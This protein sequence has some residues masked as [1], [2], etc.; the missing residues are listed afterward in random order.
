LQR[1]LQPGEIEALDRTRL[2]RMRMPQPDSLF[3]DRAARLRQLADGNPIADY[4]RFVARLVDAQRAL[5]RQFAADT[6]H[7]AETLDAQ[8]IAQAQRHAMPL[9]PAADH[10]PAAW[11]QALSGILAAVDAAAETPA[12]L[13]DAVARL[14]ALPALDQEDL[15]QQ[16]LSGTLDPGD[17]ALAPLLMA[18]LQVIYTLRASRIPA[19]EVPYT[20]P[21]TVCPVCASAP[22]AS[23]QRLGVEPS[24]LR[25]A[26]CG[27]CATEWH[28]VRVK[29]T[30]CESTEGVR[31]QGVDGA[32][33]PSGAVLA[34]TCDACGNYRKLA[35]QEKDPLAEP[36]ADD[37]ASIVLD[38]LMGETGFARASANP[39]LAL[40]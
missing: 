39:L 9:L 24:G 7:A 33:G 1:I 36:L 28:M 19:S 10:L 20:I 16:A 29:C 22:V 18:A 31:Y 32:N 13:R 6:T 11:P 37:L 40:G 17:A 26:H 5:A 34:E 35:N 25:F 38:L 8:A 30:H 4:L 15:L 12:P 2:P 27:L 21:A 14:R 3:T 23:V